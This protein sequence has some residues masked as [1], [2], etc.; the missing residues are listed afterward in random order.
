M[1][2]ERPAAAPSIS[3]PDHPPM[4]HKPVSASAPTTPA[5]ADAP[6]HQ[7]PVCDTAIFF[8]RPHRTAKSFD[9]L[10]Q[11]ILPIQVCRHDV[12]CLEPV[13]SAYSQLGAQIVFV[14]ACVLIGSAR[15][16]H[17]VAVSGFGPSCPRC[18]QQELR[19]RRAVQAKAQRSI[20]DNSAR[21]P[22]GTVRK[23]LAWLLV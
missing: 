16:L 14:R 4:S 1:S 19:R 3:R 8:I 6:S 11:L 18:R 13:L 23:D 10:I 20:S 15:S 21:L 7:V 22:S 9:D 12:Y 5:L 17:C 2:A